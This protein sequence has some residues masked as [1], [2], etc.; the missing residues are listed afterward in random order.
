MVSYGTPNHA[1]KARAGPIPPPNSPLEK[2]PHKAGNGDLT[3]TCRNRHC[4]KCQSLARAKMRFQLLRQWLQERQAD[5]ARVESTLLLPVEYFHVVF[6][7]PEE[8]A[9]IAFQNKKEVYGILFRAAAETLRLISADPK[10]L[11]AEI[12]WIAI[13]HTWGQNLLHRPHLH[14][15]VSGGGISP[16]GAHWIACRPGFFLP[17]RVLS[18]LFHRLFLEMRFQLLRQYLQQAFDKGKLQFF[19][20]LVSLRDR[21]CFQKTIAAA[22]KCEWVVYAKAPFAGPEQVLQYLGRYTH[23]VAIYNNRLAGMEN[24]QVQWCKS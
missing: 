3:I 14:C 9:A 16:G 15:L 2:T 17:V 10:H 8:I 7:I 19:S 22:R 20:S 23:R 11:G 24:G 1:R 6:T 13:L 4:P 21:Q 5:G 18:R 12:G